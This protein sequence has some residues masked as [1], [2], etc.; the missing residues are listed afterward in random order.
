MRDTKSLLLILLSIGLVGTWIYY[1]YNKANPTITTTDRFQDSTL[2][3]DSLRFYSHSLDQ[4][5][6]RLNDLALTADSLQARLNELSKDTAVRVQKI[7]PSYSS[8][9]AV[10][11]VPSPVRQNKKALPIPMT[12]LK[13][14][15]FSLEQ[16]KL[17]M[18]KTILRL[19][20]ELDVLRKNQQRLLQEHRILQEKASVFQLFELRLASVQV[21][22][23]KEIETTKTKNTDKFEASLVVQNNITDLRE[24]EIIIVLLQPNGETL[25]NTPSAGSFQT[26]DGI[27][28]SFTQAISFNYTEGL[29]KKLSFP[30]E[31]RNRQEG[32]YTLQVWHQG[33]QIGQTVRRLE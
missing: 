5:Q 24:T 26:K 1:I 10:G 7:E 29:Q 33:V 2:L 8:A 18:T 32:N 20:Q 4:T 3:S 31:I 6:S 11:K 13:E 16:E 15:N 27:K 9:S 22:A 17:E 30:I 12:G 28:K 23:G 14:Q 21:K 19:T 25:I